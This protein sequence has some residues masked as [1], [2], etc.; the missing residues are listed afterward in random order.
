MAVMILLILINI[1]IVFIVMYVGSQ[2]DEVK[3]LTPL[4]VETGEHGVTP[5]AVIAAPSAPAPIAPK[6]EPHEISV[7]VLERAVQLLDSESATERRAAVER[8]T[9]AQHQTATPKIVEALSDLDPLVRQSA[10]KG[11]T[12]MGWTPANDEEKAAHDAAGQG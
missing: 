8:L 9:G 4:E 10:A 1:A 7:E 6:P 5:R 2:P 3:H 12:A 11:L